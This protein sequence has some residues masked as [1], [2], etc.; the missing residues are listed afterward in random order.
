MRAKRLRPAD[1]R[2][3]VARA[4]SGNGVG[5]PALGPAT[6]RHADSSQAKYGGEDRKRRP[7]VPWVRN[8]I[9]GVSC[10]RLYDGW[11][12]LAPRQAEPSWRSESGLPFTSA[13]D[14]LL[15]RGWVVGNDDL[16]ADSYESI[17]EAVDGKRPSRRRDLSG[18]S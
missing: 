6:W 13:G 17:E 2:A 14:S 8:V 9:R 18:L 16:N 7:H 11:S 4:T 10:A 15:G 3:I 5:G 12:S 1:G